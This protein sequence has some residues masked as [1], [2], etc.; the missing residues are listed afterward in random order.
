MNDAEY[1]ERAKKTTFYQK[2]LAD[3]NTQ[4]WCNIPFTTKQDLRDADEFDLL[5]SQHKI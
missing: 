2:K 4:M 1:I 5:G 3:V